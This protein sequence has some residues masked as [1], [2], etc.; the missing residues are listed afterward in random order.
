MKNK[1]ADCFIL[2]LLLLVVMLDISGYY[3]CH[4]PHLHVDRVFLWGFC[5]FMTIGVFL[6]N[7]IYFGLFDTNKVAGK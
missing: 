6:I 4:T 1:L 5:S 7:G 2:F 3:V